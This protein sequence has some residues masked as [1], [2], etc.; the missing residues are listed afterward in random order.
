MQP[1]RPWRA[2]V[3]PPGALAR[4]AYRWLSPFPLLYLTPGC[5]SQ[6][7]CHPYA[8]PSTCRLACGA[9]SPS[10]LLAI[11]MTLG[12]VM[13]L[14]SVLA[15][16]QRQL[17][18]SLVPRTAGKACSGFVQ[19]ED[20]MGCNAGCQSPRQH[21][22]CPAGRRPP[23]THHPGAGLRGTYLARVRHQQ[24]APVPPPQPHLLHRVGHVSSQQLLLRARGPGPGGQPQRGAGSSCRH[25]RGPPQF[26]VSCPQ[27]CPRAAQPP[28]W[29]LSQS[30]PTHPPTLDPRSLRSCCL[31]QSACTPSSPPGSAHMPHLAMAVEGLP[32]AVAIAPEYLPQV[33]PTPPPSLAGVAANTSWILRNCGHSAPQHPP[34]PQTTTPHPPTAPT[35]HP[36]T[37][38]PTP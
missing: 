9:H 14:Y 3:A 15:C 33:H 2:H 31:E 12:E 19:G 37:A 29:A 8:H 20:P 1:V 30:Q 5:G 36:P 4:P 24:E 7:C 35:H 16:R 32:S 34:P 13:R 27:L 28:L 38:P 10:L 22:A 21:A 23:G 26:C 18:G 25:G 17:G 6:L 11:P